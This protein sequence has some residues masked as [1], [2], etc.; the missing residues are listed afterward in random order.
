[1]TDNSLPEIVT[2]F[3]A[4]DSHFINDLHA[5]FV[6]STLKVILPES[7]LRAEGEENKDW[8]EQGEHFNALMPYITSTFC[9]SLPGNLSFYSISRYRSNAF[10]FFFEMITHWLVPG[11]R[12]NA[13][14][15]FVTDFSMPS[16]GNQLFTL[17]E[18]V[19]RIDDPDDLEH[20]HTNLST[21]E[22]ELRLGMESSY[23]ARRILE[24]KGVSA[25]EKLSL[26]Q[27]Q[28]AQLIKRLPTYF[29]YDLMGEMQHL[30][31]MCRDEFKA[32]RQSQHLT[33]IISFLFLFRK[34][35]KERV[36][37]IPPIRHVNV[38]IFRSH[39]ENEAGQ[40][41]VLCLI[42]GV[43]FLR[44]KE[45]FEK[46]HLLSAIR[47]HIPLATL[48]EGSYISS[49][50][51]HENFCHLYIEVEKSNGQ[52]FT[53]EEI[54]LLTRELPLE[55]KDLIEHTAH[56]VFMPRNEEEIMRNVLIL[57]SQIKFVR[58]IPQVV[59]N[60]DEQT[61]SHLVFNVI[62]V[63]IVKPG[64]KS[65]QEILQ[66]S[67]TYLE[68]IHERT[69]TVGYLRN[70]YTKEAVIF[71]VKLPKERF[72]RKD[73][74]ID[75]YK[76]RQT[77]VIE[78]SNLVGDIRDFNGGM[79]AKQNETLSAVRDL[80]RGT[81]K[82]NDHLLENLFFSVMPPVIRT[83]IEPIA[84]KSLFT[85]IQLLVEKGVMEND[86]YSHTIHA[87]PDFV[88]VVVRGG[89]TKLREEIS[90]RLSGPQ[91]HPSEIASS[92]L[93]VHEV[94]YL[95]Y[96]YRCDDEQKQS[97]FCKTMENTISTWSFKKT[98]ANR[99]PTAE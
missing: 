95:A 74:S 14:S 20:I 85:M 7:L 78:L 33:R 68:Y 40:Q 15:L 45:V 6:R 83:L 35:M 29:D 41:P 56:P 11:K 63:Q 1:M 27:E 99:P 16:V 5:K 43:N 61:H 94:P 26:V 60:F 30:F 76:A 59:I 53:T 91:Y 8:Q 84:I 48:V 9:D 17:C 70:K 65:L 71:R 51:G 72:L 77:V 80:M 88:Y 49:R 86:G 89:S 54:S 67:Q 4:P 55:L 69:K 31:V 2:F 37:Q 98:K 28:I 21:V 82:Y 64:A 52:R 93:R 66:N 58:D 34:G 18:V 42:V 57:S 38:K 23:Y 44:E 46:R 81:T 36:K 90:K 24:I 97:A 50:R 12:L 96:I 79:I 39:I 92:S 13:V 75:L 62:F 22:T 10:R 3:D 19:I 73:H 87:V 32:A 47:S 25:D